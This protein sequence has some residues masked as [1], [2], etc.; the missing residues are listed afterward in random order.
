MSQTMI[1]LP[2]HIYAQY[3]QLAEIEDRPFEEVVSEVLE[4]EIDKR[5]WAIVN[6]SL[7]PSDD[8][9]LHELL[10]KGN[11]GTST[12]E[13]RHEAQTLVDLVEQQMLE[14]S[15]ALALLQ[16]RGHDIK[17]YLGLRE[18]EQDSLQA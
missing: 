12:P 10:D 16:R 2:Q 5:L 14:R 15:K 8:A 11:A 18:D 1:T 13:E 3:Q 4:E 7:S 6:Q 17:G 9:R